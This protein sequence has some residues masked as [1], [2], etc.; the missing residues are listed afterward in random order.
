[1][2]RTPK[3][4]RKKINNMGLRTFFSSLSG[5]GSEGK[6]SRPKTPPADPPAD[7]PSDTEPENVGEPRRVWIA[8]MGVTGA[9]K[10]TFISHLVDEKV[11]IGHDLA[12]CE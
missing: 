10:S 1:L 5:T 2:N 8:L 7:L 3:K 4:S 6:D 12:S 9:G 11:P